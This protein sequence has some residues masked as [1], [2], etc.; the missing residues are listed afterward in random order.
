MPLILALIGVA[1]NAPQEL[2]GGL[3]AIFLIEELVFKGSD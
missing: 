3:L 2:V 1:V